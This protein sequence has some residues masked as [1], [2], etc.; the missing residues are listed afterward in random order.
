MKTFMVKMLYYCVCMS[1]VYLPIIYLYNGEGR[2]DLQL[3]QHPHIVSELQRHV[4]KIL[5][6][7]MGW[8]GE[9]GD[10]KGRGRRG[11]KGT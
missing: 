8:K 3:C 11:G 9:G 6:E 4:Q 10:G 7:G 1:V 2:G 5:K